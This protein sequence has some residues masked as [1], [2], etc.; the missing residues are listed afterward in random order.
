M[1]PAYSPGTDPGFGASRSS[2]LEANLVYSLCE[3]V[4]APKQNENVTLESCLILLPFWASWTFGCIG[5]YIL[6]V[7][8]RLAGALVNNVRRGLECSLPCFLSLA[9]LASSPHEVV[10][11]TGRSTSCG[12]HKYGCEAESHKQASSAFLRRDGLSRVVSFSSLSSIN[13]YS[14]SSWS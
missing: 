6:G 1:V 9:D 12:P 4:H 8:I 14:C 3:V 7:E 5:A 10:F 11:W 13:S 2:F